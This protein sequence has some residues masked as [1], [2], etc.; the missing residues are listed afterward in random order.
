MDGCKLESHQAVRGIWLLSVPLLQMKCR[1]GQA[2][3]LGIRPCAVGPTQ[4]GLKKGDLIPIFVMQGYMLTENGF[5]EE[6]GIST[7]ARGATLQQQ[8]SLLPDPLDF[9][10]RLVPGMAHIDPTADAASQADQERSI[11]LTAAALRQGLQAA[12]PLQSGMAQAVSSEQPALVNFNDFDSA[13]LQRAASSQQEPAQSV[14]WL[15]W[16]AVPPVKGCLQHFL[17]SLLQAFMPSGLMG[18]P[19]ETSDEPATDGESVRDQ[20]IRMR[21]WEQMPKWET[22]EEVWIKEHGNAP[23][24]M[25]PEQPQQLTAAQDTTKKAQA[26]EQTSSH[27]EDPR[28]ATLMNTLL[29]LAEPQGG[30]S[31]S[32]EHESALQPTEQ[33][34]VKLSEAQPL[35]KAWTGLTASMLKPA[36]DAS[37]VSEGTQQDMHGAAAVKL[38]IPQPLGD[39]WTSL[40]AAML[41]ASPDRDTMTNQ[42]TAPNQAAA[43]AAEPAQEGASEAVLTSVS[44]EPRAAV[45][46]RDAV[47]AAARELAANTGISKDAALDRAVSAVLQAGSYAAPDLDPLW[48]NRRFGPADTETAWD[49]DVLRAGGDGVSAT[50]MA[51]PPQ[52]GPQLE[53][54]RRG[55]ISRVLDDISGAVR[56][57]AAALSRHFA[58]RLSTAD[59]E[60]VVP[61]ELLHLFLH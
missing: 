39:A 19:G 27:D 42:D 35:G 15:Q 46:S 17:R 18:S 32:V 4:K 61:G 40:T 31:L 25:D 1:G 23:S 14:F 60:R 54:Q 55:V 16:P 28:E 53:V 21:W 10:A 12:L 34:M 51:V 41:R 24:R 52:S 22:E 48:S 49:T 47:A 11:Y 33:G 8:R 37:R 20:M 36:L 57:A 13:S 58:G 5:C 3:T 50:T 29:G 2:Q 7:S 30:E 38:T 6:E 9:L 26:A 59:S 56:S 43:A 45:V 44:E